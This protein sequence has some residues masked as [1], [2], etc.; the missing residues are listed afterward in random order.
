M[1]TTAVGLCDDSI[2]DRE[3]GKHSFCSAEGVSGRFQAMLPPKAPCVGA[4]I[5][6]PGRPSPLLPL[7]PAV[8]TGATVISAPAP[9][10]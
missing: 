1:P 5:G 7:S 10:A 3:I 8:W 4:F 9:A 6:D 2:L